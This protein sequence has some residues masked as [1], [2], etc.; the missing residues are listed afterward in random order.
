LG[1]GVAVRFA[2]LLAKILAHARLWSEVMQH[3][4]L[5][6]Y[7]SLGRLEHRL[8]VFSFRTYFLYFQL[9][10][11]VKCHLHGICLLQHGG[12]AFLYHPCADSGE[13]EKLKEI[14]KSCLRRY[15]I[16]PYRLL[17]LKQVFRKYRIF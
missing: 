4:K 12:V 1:R 11:A 7:N 17:P 8:F 16:T 3:N 6:D 13:V 2:P 5:I 15:V 14:A 10:L 9:G